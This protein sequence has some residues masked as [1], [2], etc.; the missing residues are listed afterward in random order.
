MASALPLPP[1]G[2]SAVDLPMRLFLLEQGLPQYEKALCGAGYE[3]AGD[4]IDVGKA[5]LQGLGLLAGHAN[6]LMRAANKLE[7][8]PRAVSGIS[9]PSGG[10]LGTPLFCPAPDGG[11]GAAGGSLGPAPSA[12]APPLPVRACYDG[13]WHDAEVVNTLPN[14]DY[15]VR[16]VSD[17]T[18]S[19]VS[20]LD[21]TFPAPA[22]APVALEKPPPT[23]LD[24]PMQGPHPPPHPTQPAQLP[25]SAPSAHHGKPELQGGAPRSPRGC[26]A[27]EGGGRRALQKAYA[28]GCRNIAERFFQALLESWERDIAAAASR[29]RLAELQ[30]P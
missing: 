6:R 13:E 25:A 3:L 10:T 27:A 1:P 28:Q 11:F 4:L 30:Q 17:G 29:R 18:H 5:E 12:S 15:E 24:G 26:A 9:A 14:G 20:H 8:P 16:W 22:C 7:E 23:P 19:L 2:P 21:V